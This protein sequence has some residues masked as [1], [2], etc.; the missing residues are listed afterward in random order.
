MTYPGTTGNWAQAVS[1]L[2]PFNT[3]NSQLVPAGSHLYWV[4]A[5]T[6]AAGVAIP[7]GTTFQ[8]IWEEV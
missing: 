1:Q 4:Q 5:N 7:A 8:V 6:G 3:S 2:V